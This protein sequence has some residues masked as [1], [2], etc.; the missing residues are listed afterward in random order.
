MTIIGIRKGNFK[1]FVKK[2]LDLVLRR[3][4]ES[5]K[6]LQNRK[7]YRAVFLNQRVVTSIIPGREKF[8]WN[9]S[10]QFSKHY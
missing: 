5:I 7:L 8:S 3:S 2:I 4:R 9:L 10:F 6:V 1:F